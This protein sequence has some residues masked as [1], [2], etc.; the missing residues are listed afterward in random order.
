MLILTCSM[1]GFSKGGLSRASTMGLPIWRMHFLRSY[2]AQRDQS[3]SSLLS[4]HKFIQLTSSDI[5]KR[6]FTM[7]LYIL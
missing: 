3:S 2:R 7:S 6:A 1:L 5:K 4:N